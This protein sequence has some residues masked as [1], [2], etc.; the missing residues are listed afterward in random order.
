MPCCS[1]T[2]DCLLPVIILLDRCGFCFCSAQLQPAKL[3]VTSSSVVA[4][5]CVFQGLTR[6]IDSLPIQTGQ[7][8]AHRVNRVSAVLQAS[9]S[10]W[11]PARS[12]TRASRSSLPEVRPCFSLPL[13]RATY[14]SAIFADPWFSL[15]PSLLCVRVRRPDHCGLQLHHRGVR[16]HREP[17]RRRR[18]SPGVLRF[19][20]AS[21]VL[22]RCALLCFSR[23]LRADL[24]P[25][26][27]NAAAQ[28]H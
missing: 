15:A 21:F 18:Q 12:C 26:C 9:R 28:P 24:P 19:C 17:D 27:S 1:S 6:S 3:T 16:G 11:G 5:G 8:P 14:L 7:W 4:S 23:S 2:C 20:S 13:A 25:R 22:A 10:R